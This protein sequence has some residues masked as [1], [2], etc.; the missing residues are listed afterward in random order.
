MEALTLLSFPNPVN[1]SNF[2]GIV[3]YAKVVTGGTDYF[4][5]AIILMFCAIVFI[6]FMRLGYAKAFTLSAFLAFVL[7]FLL[8]AFNVIE[9]DYW[10]FGSI[11]MAGI[12]IIWIRT[13]RKS[14][15]E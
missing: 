9:S 6:S 12:G 2:T 7:S 14:Y 8:R 5:G 13:Q 11:L 15:E 10:V 3:N 1:V 4:G